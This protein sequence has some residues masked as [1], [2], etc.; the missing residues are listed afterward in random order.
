M[1]NYYEVLGATMSATRDELKRCYHRLVRKYHPD[2]KKELGDDQNFCLIDEAWKVLGD[3]NLRKMYDAKIKASESQFCHP[4]QEEI[5]I[6][7]LSWN[8]DLEQFEKYCRCGGQYA[9]HQDDS[10]SGLVLIDCDN[11]SLSIVVDCDIKE[12]KNDSSS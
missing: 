2:K 5:S 10:K 4:V 7:E 3:D 8:G 11:C 1:P 12:N 9:L 6:T